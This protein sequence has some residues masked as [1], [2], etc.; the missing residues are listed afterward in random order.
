MKLLLVEGEKTQAQ[1]IVL[2]SVD[3]FIF[4]DF[5]CMKLN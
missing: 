3:S 2:W 1:V 5:M 4:C